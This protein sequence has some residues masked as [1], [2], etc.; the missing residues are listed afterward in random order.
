LSTEHVITKQMENNT[1]KSADNK[2]AFFF[3][4]L[5]IYPL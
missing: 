1:G 5:T 3:L 2:S 4:L